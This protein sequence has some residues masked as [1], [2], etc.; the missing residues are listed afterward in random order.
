M[1]CTDKGTI[2]SALE[3]QWEQFIKEK[4]MNEQFICSTIGKEYDVYKMFK[5]FPDIKAAP[6]PSSLRTIKGEGEGEGEDIIPPFDDELIN[7]HKMVD[8]DL[9]I[10]TRTCIAHTRP[11]DIYALFWALPINDF[12]QMTPGIVK[13]LIKYDVYSEDD[14]KE[15]DEVCEKQRKMGVNVVENILK[16]IIHVKKQPAKKPKGRKNAQTTAPPPPAPPLEEPVIVEEKKLTHTRKLS[17]GTCKK[18][19]QNNLK[20]KK[21]KGAKDAFSNCLAI[22]V[23][24][25][26]IDSDTAVMPSTPLDYHEYHVKI[27]NTGKIEIPGIKNTETFKGLLG[28]ITELIT[29]VTSVPTSYIIDEHELVLINSTF[30]CGHELNREA[31]SSILSNKYGLTCTYDP[32]VYPGILC[33]FYYNTELPE[34]LQTGICPIDHKPGA[35]KKIVKD[36]ILTITY[37]IFRTGNILILGKCVE[38][39]IRYLYNHMKHILEVERASVES[40]AIVR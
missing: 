12:S 20:K 27:F 18:D 10:S 22:N 11:L 6:L 24:Y 31:L 21:I 26:H 29:Q 23:R 33:E 17:I 8:T 35:S 13:K 25:Q 28:L 15:L 34:D 3:S 36:T 19:E 9:H 2:T 7:D 37:M 30:Y 5:M 14:I 32:S 1:A 16:H 4:R 38:P 40:G 39:V